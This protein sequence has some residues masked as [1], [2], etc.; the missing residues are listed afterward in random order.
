MVMAFTLDFLAILLGALG[1][2]CLLVILFERQ[3]PIVPYA[4]PFHAEEGVHSPDP[5]AEEPFVSMP[6]HLRTNA[7]MVAWMTQELPRL[8]EEKA[9]RSH[10]G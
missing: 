5:D 9:M 6:G 10:R 1:V 3:A 2:L 8:T 4:E 7:E